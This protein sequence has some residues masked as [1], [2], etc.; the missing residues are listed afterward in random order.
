MKIDTIFL[1]FFSKKPAHDSE[2]NESALK[3]GMV[4]AGITAALIMEVWGCFYVTP[5]MHT[6]RGAVQG[7]L[8]WK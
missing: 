5:F 1:P 8:W 6:R 7:L 3:D 2:T 4:P